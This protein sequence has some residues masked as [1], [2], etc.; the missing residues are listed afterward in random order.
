LKTRLTNLEHLITKYP[1]LVHETIYTYIKPPW[2]NPTNI[3][4]TISYADK[5]Q[6]K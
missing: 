5:E 2:W 1:K 6:A 3:T 4:T